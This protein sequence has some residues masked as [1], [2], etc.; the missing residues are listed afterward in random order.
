M[1]TASIDELTERT[2]VVMDDLLAI[3]HTGELLRRITAG[4]LAAGLGPLITGL[5]LA[6][7]VSGTLPVANGGTGQTTLQA[8]INALLAA[9]GALAQG[10]VFYYNGTNV[11]KLAAGTA[12]QRLITGGT[13]A[14]P[15][16]TSEV[17]Y[18]TGDGGAVTQA[19][20]RSTGVT[21]NKLCG[22]ITMNN[23]SLAASANVS[24]VVTNSLVAATDTIVVNV[25]TMATGLPVAS[26]LSVAA[27]S[28]TVMVRNVH[29]STAD[30]TAD[31][32]NFAVVKAVNS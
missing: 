11:T 23:A 22:Q 9:S 15:S 20:N 8:A 32:L 17:G 5:L 13:G 29:A 2:S 16:W 4:N 12:G 21:L 7:G 6:S 14:N 24:F 28:F 19:T 25:A 26:I 3:Q 30:T 10:D 1:A 27:G 31:V 18:H